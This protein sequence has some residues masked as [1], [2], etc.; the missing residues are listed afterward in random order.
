MMRL[1]APCVLIVLLG[2]FGS[3]RHSLRER[4]LEFEQ[5]LRARIGQDISEAISVLGAP[6]TVLPLPNYEWK[7]SYGVETRS[8]TV[9][10]S[11]WA[12]GRTSSEGNTCDLRY[13]VDPNNR[14][15]AT[16]YEGNSCF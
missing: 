10:G 15:V 11:G 7:R 6:T 8:G 14:I 2:C 13:T 9:G 5:R 1:L 16:H 4:Q 3:S 12:A